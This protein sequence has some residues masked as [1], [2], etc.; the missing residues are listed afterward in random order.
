MSVQ[1]K[2]DAYPYQDYGIIPGKAVAIPPPPQT[3]TQTAQL[4]P[5]EI[6]LERNHITKDNQQV[7]FKTGQTATAEIITRQRR[8]ADLLLDPI[9]QLRNGVNL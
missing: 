8:I 5:A 4:Y 1:V 3:D 9:K 6:Q 7:L 2:L